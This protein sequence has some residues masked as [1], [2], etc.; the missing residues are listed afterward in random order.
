M[1]GR[2]IL[3]MVLILWDISWLNVCFSSE[4]TRDGIERMDV[5]EVISLLEDLD[6]QVR[7]VILDYGV[8]KFLDNKKIQM[9]LIELLKR[10]NEIREE[11]G[12]QWDE[13][14]A[15]RG[16]K[17]P[18]DWEPKNLKKGVSQEGYAHLINIVI[19]LG[20]ERAIPSLVESVTHGVYTRPGVE[21]FGAS[22]IKPLLEQLER[23]KNSVE[24]FDIIYVL[25]KIVEKAKDISQGI[26]GTP[27][28]SGTPTTK[29]LFRMP[30]SFQIESMRNVFIKYL[31][32]PNRFTRQ[33]V[34]RNLGILGDTSV[35]PLLKPIAE[36]DP[37]WLENVEFPPISPVKGY[38]PVREEAQRV[39]KLLEEKKKQEDEQKGETDK[40]E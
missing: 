23:D 7:S 20:D 5:E 35:I 29:V 21:S 32:D 25:G 13:E 24:K 1:K 33:L 38:Y 30:T 9:A 16:K 17:P 6:P 11:W 15:K 37:Y 19:N 31:N 3:V 40:K 27:T 14:Y 26:N 39:L 4:I 10:E 8:P 22:V 12:K 18:E 28:T 36:N 34:I 2:L